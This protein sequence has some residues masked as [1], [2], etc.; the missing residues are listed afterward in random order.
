MYETYPLRKMLWPSGLSIFQGAMQPD[1]PEQEFVSVYC[2]YFAAFLVGGLLCSHRQ[3]SRAIL[4]NG[5]S[6]LTAKAGP[7]LLPIPPS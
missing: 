5:A 6:N 7:L 4:L 1:H 3:A 2:C